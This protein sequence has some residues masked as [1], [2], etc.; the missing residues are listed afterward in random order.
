MDDSSGSSGPLKKKQKK[1]IS[2]SEGQAAV[3]ETMNESDPDSCQLIGTTGEFDSE[4]ELPEKGTDNNYSQIQS[5]G[6]LEDIVPL[7]IR[8]PFIVS[9]S[10]SHLS[11]SPPTSPSTISWSPEDSSD[12]SFAIGNFKYTNNSIN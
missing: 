2:S 9:S 7:L 11:S 10:S 5:Q 4:Q 1:W 6:L 3:Y 8:K 12:C